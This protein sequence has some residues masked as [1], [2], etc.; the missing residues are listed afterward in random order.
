MQRK[1]RS[2]SLLCAVFNEEAFCTDFVAQG[3]SPAG[4]PK[5]VSERGGPRF[6]E[7]IFREKLAEGS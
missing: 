1:S 5:G 2:Q 4:F 6:A 7:R 3:G